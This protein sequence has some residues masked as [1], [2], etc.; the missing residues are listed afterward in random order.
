MYTDTPDVKQAV[1]MTIT[2][3][4]R[5]DQPAAEKMLK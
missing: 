4:I 3:R 5:L 2:F 1:L